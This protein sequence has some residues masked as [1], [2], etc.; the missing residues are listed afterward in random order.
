MKLELPNSAKNWFSIAGFMIAV[1]SFSM[2]VFLFVISTFFSGTQIYLGLIIY[3]ILPII[4][5]AG[6][7]MVPVG[8]YWARKRRRVSG[9]ELPI[10][11]LN[12]RQHRNA[13]FIFLIGTT[14]L[15]FSSAVGSYEAYHYTESVSF[16]GQVCHQVMQPE[17]ESYQHSSH[18]RVACAECHIGSGADWY[19][20]AKMSGLHQVYAVLLDTF[21]RPIP[22]PIT[23]LRP[24]RETC[25]QCHWP[26]K[27]YPREERLE[28]YFLGDEENSQWDV[29]LSMKVGPVHK[30]SGFSEGIHWHVDP[31][32]KVEYIYTDERR[33]EIPWV[34]YTNL[35]TGEVTV[36]SASDSLREIE[37][38]AD[39]AN[40]RTM[41]CL[42]CH[43]RP[44]HDYKS[45][46]YFINHAISEGS[47]PKELPGIKALARE[48]CEEEISSSDSIYS[49]IKSRIDSFYNEEY[50]EI[51]EENP[52]LI[53]K[54]TEGLYEAY[55]VNIF[56][57]MKARWDAYP[58]NIGHLEF[59][60]CFRC[61]DDGHTD[62]A[63]ETISRDCNACHLIKVQGNENAYQTA[64]AF[65][66]LK[67]VHP[68]DEVDEEDWQEG[69]CTDCHTGTDP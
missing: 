47:I 21:P 49:F 18:A 13:L 31:N 29:M 44:A 69:L 58:N 65:E 26:K 54:A 56:P 10:L 5:V 45:P 50:P 7:L 68:G 35:K 67:F 6:L 62:S 66:G 59:N 40:L 57:D 3:I 33:Q 38:A 55:R 22:T 8:M 15:L 28:Q 36:Y 4:M 34:R 20:K 24:A 63:G 37:P 14:I 32:N 64:S 11:D 53:R 2:I 48:I 12:L 25:E 30:S 51:A 19:V 42:D 1:V 23:N 9:S 43:N 52:G 41:D 60:G 17:F 61:H 46:R 27:F 16:C 39:A